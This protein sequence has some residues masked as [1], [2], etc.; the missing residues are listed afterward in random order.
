[1]VLT[2]ITS[3]SGGTNA[4]LST[5]SLIFIFILV[6]ALAYFTTK[7]IAKYQNNILNSKSNIRVIESFRIGNNK[8]IAIVRIGEA[9]YALGIGKEEITMLDR[10]NP[11]ELVDFHAPSSKDEGRK[12]DFKEILSQIKNKDSKD[13]EDSKDKKDDID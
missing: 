5:L 10:L 11:D 9:Y 7:F 4:I 6:V 2:G 12:F 1:M 8:F 3:S 13:K